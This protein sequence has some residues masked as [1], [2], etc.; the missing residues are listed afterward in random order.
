MTRTTDGTVWMVSA[1]T[2]VVT[3]PTDGTVWVVSAQ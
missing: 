3:G 1:Q 2:G